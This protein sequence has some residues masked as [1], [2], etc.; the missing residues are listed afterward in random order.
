MHLSQAPKT[1]HFGR[2][3]AQKADDW[4]EIIC[5][6]YSRTELRAASL[7]RFSARLMATFSD[8]LGFNALVAPGLHY[9]RPK[10]QIEADGQDGYVLF[11]LQEGRAEFEQQDKRLLVQPGDMLL[12]RHGESFD[13]NFPQPYRAVSLKVSAQVMLAHG[14][15]LTNFSPQVLENNSLSQRLATTMMA[16]IA[17]EMAE[18]EAPACPK[19]L[20]AVLDVAANSIPLNQDEGPSRQGHGHHLQKLRGYLHRN[21]DDDG[22]DLEKMAKICGISTRSLNRSFATNGTT[23]MRWVWEERLTL[24]RDALLSQRARNITEVSYAH[25]FKDPSHFSAAFKR[26][27]GVSP[28]HLLRGH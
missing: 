7:N 24:A 1:Y 25:G 28:A 19:L 4:H 15:G 12:Y 8:W 26:R 21:L 10:A 5:Q 2:Y 18:R 9:H 16:Q 3:Q 14:P 20:G 27:F 22:L 23:P 13:I 6:S 17:Q 11:M